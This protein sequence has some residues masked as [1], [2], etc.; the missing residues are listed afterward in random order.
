MAGFNEETQRA[1][2]AAGMKGG[3]FYTKPVV[4]EALKFVDGLEPE[5]KKARQ[6]GPTQGSKTTKPHG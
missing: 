3:P 4:Q 1:K 6:E 2:V 5:V